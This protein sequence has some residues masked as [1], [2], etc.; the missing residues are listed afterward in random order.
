MVAAKFRSDPTHPSPQSR[1][2][3]PGEWLCPNAPSLAHSTRLPDNSRLGH[4]VVPRRPPRPTDRDCIVTSEGPCPHQQ[5]NSLN[6]IVSQVL[7]GQ[8]SA[9]NTREFTLSLF[10]QEND[11]EGPP[12]RQLRSDH[13]ELIGAEVRSLGSVRGRSRSTESLGFFGLVTPG[14]ASRFGFG[15]SAEGPSAKQLRFLGFLKQ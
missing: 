5:E 1:W 4:A 2:I 12:G 8:F 14:S 11:P 13:S 9:P 6:L 3:Q 10:S 15:G 7:M